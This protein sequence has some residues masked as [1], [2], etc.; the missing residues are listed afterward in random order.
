H[1]IEGFLERHAS[2]IRGAVLEVQEPDYTHR[3]GGDRVTRSD[4]VDL[5]ASNP[6]ATVLSDLRSASN[7][8]SSTYDCIVLTPKLHVIDRMSAVV[9]ECAR[10]LK[11][12][13]VLLA[14][15]PCA[16]RVCL[17][18][19]HDGDFWR[20]TEAGARRLFSQAFPTESL[21]VTSYGNVLVN[22]A[23]LYGL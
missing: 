5:D 7:I 8:P 22:A 10:I 18:Y 11:P 9:S 17:E 2:D 20:V 23:F 3:F 1:Y 4:V 13:G 21:E 6:R 14:T 15:L 19:G 12:G 16:S